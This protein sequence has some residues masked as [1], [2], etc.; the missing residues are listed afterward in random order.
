MTSGVGTRLA[1]SVAAFRAVFANPQIRRLQLADVGSVV[2]TWSYTIA[3]F[4]YAYDVGGAAAV[5]L[6]ALIRYLPSAVA[7]P[8]TGLLGDRYRRI[9]VMLASDLVRVVTMAGA[10]ATIA[11][12][13]S[14]LLV[15]ALATITSISATA[16]RPAKAAALPLLARTPEELTAANVATSTINSTGSFAGPAL[17]GFIV[18]AAGPEVAFA[19]NGATFLWSA[20]LIERVR[21]SWSEPRRPK[22]PRSARGVLGELA[23]GF[24]AVA[25]APAVRIVVL[26]MAAQTLVLGTLSVFVVILALEIFE[27]GEAGVGIFNSALGIGGLIGSV[28]AFALVGRPRLAA[29][30]AVGIVGW[31]LPLAVVGGWPQ[32]ALALVLFG[33]IGV[34]NTLV[35]VSGFTLLQRTGDDAVLARVFGVLNTLIYISVAV[36]GALTPLLIALVG[37]RASLVVVGAL[38]PAL[39][40]L[41]W[42]ALARIDRRAESRQRELALLQRLPIFAPLPVQTLER[43]AHDLRPRT[44]G[45]GQTIV[46]EGDVGDLF[47]IVADGRVTVS[48]NGSP[49]GELGPG[50]CFG[51]IALLRDVPRTATVTAAEDTELYALERDL[52]VAAVSGDPESANAADTLVSERLGTSRLGT[53]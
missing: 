42:P 16:F 37:E 34:A 10:A 15:Y 19:F 48:A 26:L 53:G 39:V 18:A 11:L 45:A 25:R 8:F 6:V 50:S 12:D 2:G 5:G 4:V 24:A 49:L 36:G 30:F 20:F 3:L 22:A 1:A 33:L 31:S 40:L 52:F 29:A 43:L 41:S 44:V 23:T 7:S 46:R 38:L 35:D 21:R 13:G 51:E 9:P 47:Y 28:I 14:P 17:G 27:I 32:L